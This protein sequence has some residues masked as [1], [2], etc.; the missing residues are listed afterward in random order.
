MISMLSKRAKLEAKCDFY[1]IFYYKQVQLEICRWMVHQSHQHR[2]HVITTHHVIVTKVSTFL[3]KVMKS[4][5]RN[6]IAITHAETMEV[7]HRFFHK[8][9]RLFNVFCTTEIIRLFLLY[10]DIN[11]LSVCSKFC[12]IFRCEILT[13]I[14]FQAFFKQQK[15]TI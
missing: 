15:W 6:V 4:P 8:P 1:Q 13:I 2:H 9:N 3:M 14:T 12:S 11:I 10:F 7:S 5:K